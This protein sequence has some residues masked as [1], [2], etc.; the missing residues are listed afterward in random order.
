MERDIIKK[1]LK[2]SE[3]DWTEENQ[4][5]API[6]EIE[7]W[8]IKNQNDI[9]E[10]LKKIK[11]F[12][13]MSPQMDWSSSDDYN[14]QNKMIALSIKGIGDELKNIYSSFETIKSEMD[15]IRNPEKYNED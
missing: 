7:T 12:Y 4:T 5:E 1:I 9:K 13:E 2:E 6:N 14:D 15:Y 11:D 10:W 3:W 8:V